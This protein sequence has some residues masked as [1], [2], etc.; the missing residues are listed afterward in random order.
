MI[1]GVVTIVIAGLVKRDGRKVRARNT[2]VASLFY[3]QQQHSA[4]P[5]RVLIIFVD[6]QQVSLQVSRPIR[7]Y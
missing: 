3:E 7:I 1:S 5:N 2:A 6:Y 4:V